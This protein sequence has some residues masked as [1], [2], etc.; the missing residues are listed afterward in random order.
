L[1]GNFNGLVLYQEIFWGILGHLGQEKILKLKLSSW[2]FIFLSF[3]FLNFH[4]ESFTL[5]Q[6]KCP[7]CPKN[8]E[9]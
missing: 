6:K 1:N 3:T 2:N 4:P 5:R 8:I 9:R 7:K